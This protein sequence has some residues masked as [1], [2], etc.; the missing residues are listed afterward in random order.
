M[1]SKIQS[2]C[3]KWLWNNYPETRGL[4]FEINNNPRN[5]IDGSLRKSMG[6]IKG[7]ADTCLLWNGKAYFIEFKDEKGKQSKSQEIWQRTIEKQNFNYFIIRTFN[8]FKLVWETL[9]EN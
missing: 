1:E 6:M 8:E 2:E 5:A 4:F 7:V 9:A 3:V